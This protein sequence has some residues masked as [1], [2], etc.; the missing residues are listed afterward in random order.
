[1]SEHGGLLGFLTEAVEIKEN[2]GCSID[3]AFEIQRQLAEE[4]LQEYERAAAESNVI[5]FRAKH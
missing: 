5:P 3:E 4:R 1:M 2:L